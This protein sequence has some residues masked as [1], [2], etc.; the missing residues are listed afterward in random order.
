MNSLLIRAS[1]VM[2]VIIT[3]Q[4]DTFKEVYKVFTKDYEAEA[5]GKLCA[6]V[7]AME[8]MYKTYARNLYIRGCQ[9]A[10]ANMQFEM[11]TAM[12]GGKA[13]EEHRKKYFEIINDEETPEHE[14]MMNWCGKAASKYELDNKDQMVMTWHLKEKMCYEQE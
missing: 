14:A 1:F 10:Y 11:F 12:A 4:H 5:R 9:V 8:D 3:V 13:T 2:L 7:M 6:E